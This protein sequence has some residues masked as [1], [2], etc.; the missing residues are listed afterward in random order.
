MDTTPFPEA[1]APGLERYWLYSKFEIDALIARLCDE[2]V[3]MTVYWGSSGQF[4]VTQIMKVDGLRNEAHFDLPSQPQ[5]QTEL[6]GVGELVCV[7]F[8]DSVKLQFSI[9]APRRS[10]EGGYPT[11]VC[12]FPDRL[13]RLQR[14]E[15]YRVRAPE[16]LSATCLV[17]Y[18]GDCSRYE[19]LRVLD[20]SVGGLAMLAYPQHFSPAPG[21]V[22]DRCYLDLAGVGTVT[23]RMRIANVDPTPSA[24]VRRCGCEFIDLSPQ[25]RMMLQRYVHRIDVEQ[26]NRGFDPRKVA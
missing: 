21:T 11:F 24:V 13:L 22:I 10:S 1:E 2:R 9:A 14:R 3:Q 17:P 15:Y 18:T 25:A 26:R 12:A 8:I 23:I 7:A 4:A 20:V 16:S 5:Q 19:A 6:L